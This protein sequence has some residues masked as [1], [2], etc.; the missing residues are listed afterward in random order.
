MSGDLENVRRYGQAAIPNSV[1]RYRLHEV[2]KSAPKKAIG[3]LLIFFGAAVFIFRET[4]VFPGLE[5]LFGIETIVG[6]ENVVYLPDGG[7]GFTNPVAMMK[8]IASVGFAGVAICLVGIWF[9][10]RVAAD[11]KNSN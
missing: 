2:M 1:L 6:K 8:W 4:I 7:Y 3:G 5:R 9:L 11:R 10:F